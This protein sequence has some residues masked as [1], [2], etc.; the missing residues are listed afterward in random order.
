LA[1]LVSELNRDGNT[2][3]TLNPADDSAAW[4]ASVFLLPDGAYEVDLGNPDSNE[5]T[6]TL[7]TDHNK[8]AQH[9]S[10][11]LDALQRTR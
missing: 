3:V 1:I 5:R 9:V 10:D 7:H 2:F 6:A 4:Y 11:W 8:I